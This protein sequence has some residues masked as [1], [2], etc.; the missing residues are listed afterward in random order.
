VDLDKINDVELFFATAYDPNFI[1]THHRVRELLDAYEILKDREM[2]DASD[3]KGFSM[4]QI[5]LNIR[6]GA[7]GSNAKKGILVNEIDAQGTPT[8]GQIDLYNY[9]KLER[10]RKVHESLDPR[11]KAA[12][13]FKEIEDAF[14]AGKEI[15]LTIKKRDLKTGEETGEELFIKDLREIVPKLMI[16]AE[17]FEKYYETIQDNQTSLQYLSTLRESSIMKHHAENGGHAQMRKGLSGDWVYMPVSGRM[18]AKYV[19]GEVG[20]T[21]I[22]FRVAGHVHEMGYYEER[23]GMTVGF[24]A[25]AVRTWRGTGMDYQIFSQTGTRTFKNFVALHQEESPLADKEN[26]TMWFGR[27]VEPDGSEKRGKIYTAMHNHYDNQMEMRR[28]YGITDFEVG[29]KIM[30]DI[31]AVHFATNPV[32]WVMS[33]GESSGFYVAKDITPLL[34]KNEEAKV[35]PRPTLIFYAKHP[36]GVNMITKETDFSGVKGGLYG[37]LEIKGF[38]ALA[39]YVQWRVQEGDI[40][41]ITNPSDVKVNFIQEMAKKKTK[42]ESEEESE[43]EYKFDHRDDPEDTERPKYATAMVTVLKEVYGAGGENVLK[44]LAE[45]VEE[46]AVRIGD[47]DVVVKEA[48][49]LRDGLAKQA[50]E[51]TGVMKALRVLTGE[52]ASPEAAKRF[53]DILH[54][55]IGGEDALTRKE[56]TKKLRGEKK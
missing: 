55:I 38:T 48:A 20:K 50:E 1:H 42:E 6:H 22:R 45:E 52:E 36:E 46:V 54:G 25:A 24:E 51:R 35:P 39:K 8:G 44:F 27:K 14:W 43:R 30:T 23:T 11:D 5:Y 17:K 13:P 34:L 37:K 4:Q 15:P 21:N 32:D 18:A 10:M 26:R 29:D 12:A 2:V 56:L 53:I 33:F 41:G 47:Q 28:G 16:P 3:E 7:D 9:A 49:E 19:R 31:V 40:P